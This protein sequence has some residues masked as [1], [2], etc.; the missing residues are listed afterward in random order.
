LIGSRSLAY[1][2]RGVTV[3]ASRQLL[4]HRTQFKHM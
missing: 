1:G 2:H 3:F 4:E